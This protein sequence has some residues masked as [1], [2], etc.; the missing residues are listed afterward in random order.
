MAR[1]APLTQRGTEA[2]PFDWAHGARADGLRAYRAGTF[3]EAHEAWERVWM[4]AHEPE[5]TLL[6]ALIQIAAALHHLKRDN[7]HGA[8][9]LFRAALERLERFDARFGGIALAP[10]RDGVRAWLPVLE[11]AGSAARPPIPPIELAAD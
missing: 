3:F 1:A 4:V 10:L 5:K 11:T 7:A 8:L 9:T 6:Q 2:E